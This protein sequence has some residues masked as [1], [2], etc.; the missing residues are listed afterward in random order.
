MK[1]A[2][3]LPSVSKKLANVPEL[4][5][6]KGLLNSP[7]KSKEKHNAKAQ[8]DKIEPMV[9]RSPPTGESIVRYALPIPS[10]KT[11]DLITE[12]E[13]VKRIAKHLKMVVAALEN[14]Y[15]TVNEDGERTG[16]KRKE[17]SS[18]LSVGDDMNSFLLCCSQFASQLEEAVKE[19]RNILESLFM[20]FQQQV[21]QM[22]EISRDQSNFEEDLPSDDK[23]VDL[24]I[25]QIANL[26][27]KF[28]E[29]K[30]R[31]KEQRGSLGTKHMDKD[32]VSETMK[33]FEAIEKQIE[34]FIKSHPEFESQFVSEV[35]SGTPYSLTDRMSIMIKIFEN[36]T[37]ML[38]R[39][40][41]DQS[42]IE[43][44]YKQMET[45]FQVLLLEK[46]LLESEIQKMKVPEK[47][48]P[49]GKDERTKKPPRPERKKE[50]ER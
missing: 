11:K 19:E 45:D 36:Q 40:L 14:T 34:E 6:K 9:L 33:S 42:I 5:Y 12:D 35:E 3:Q 38:E 44:K 18:T 21:N 48:K 17:E 49:T 50:S 20:W 32:I 25:S 24:N 10:S 4:P 8:H 39:A 47:A 2:K 22:E 13:V 31:L 7:P 16:L 37:T 26:V 41:N 23:T 46:T 1:R 28:E 43:T 29:L 15:G 27:H 30:N